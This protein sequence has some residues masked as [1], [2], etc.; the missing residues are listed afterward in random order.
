MKNKEY[1]CVLCPDGLQVPRFI[2]TVLG[3]P[4]LA[5][6]PVLTWSFGI[7]MVLITTL[8]WFTPLFWSLQTLGLT[9]WLFSC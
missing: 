5:L 6:V 1:S 7:D 8:S 3:S 2:P 4:G 9:I